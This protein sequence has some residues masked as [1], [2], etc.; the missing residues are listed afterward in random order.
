MIITIYR[1][2]DEALLKEALLIYQEKALDSLPKDKTLEK[3]NF[4][5]KFENK[6]QKLIKTEKKPYYIM[7]NTVGKRVACIIIAVLVSFTAMMSIEAIR[8]P[9]IEYIVNTFEK[10]S[11]VYFKNNSQITPETF[12]TYA[13]EYIPQGYKEVKREGTAEFMYNYVTY[14]DNKGNILDFQQDI[15]IG[16]VSINTEGV[17]IEKLYINNTESIYYENLGVQTVLFADGNYS[18][19]IRC[20]ENT[21][22][23]EELIKI[24]ESIKPEKNFLKK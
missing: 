5:D 6:M 23:K 16:S 8:R 13:P 20:Y 12:E 2:E 21:L 1:A 19:L 9:F 18:H 22:S 24:A 15:S 4:T 14:S 17:E 11:A 7:I 10:Y 3:I